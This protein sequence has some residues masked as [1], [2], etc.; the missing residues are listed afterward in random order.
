MIQKYPR[1]RF[2][3]DYSMLL[4]ETIRKKIL[5]IEEAI[6]FPASLLAQKNALRENLSMVPYSDLTGAVS[7]LVQKGKKVVIITG[8]YVPVGDPPATE[9]DGPPGA[10]ALARGLRDLGM[11][12]SLLSDE[13]TLSA[14]KAGLEILDLPEEE[15][16]IL[17]FPLD[18]SDRDHTSRMTN[19]EDQSSTSIRFAQDFFDS[20]PGQGLTHLIYIERVGPNH[21][22]ESFI[23]Q[24]RQGKPP[25]KEFE[26]ILPSSIRN[27]CFSSRLEDITRFTAKTHFLLELAAGLNLPVESIGIGDRGNE[28][29]A[30]KIPWE[31]FRQSSSTNR[32]AVFC[33]RVKT[34]TLI[35]CGISNWGGYALL[36]GAALAAGKPEILEKVTSEREGTV[37]DHLVRHGPAID[38]ITCK[39]DHS[40]DGIEFDDYVKVIERIKEIAFE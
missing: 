5:R 19:E 7:S 18:H 27:R 14:L 30:G 1:E 15:V 33:S 21:T 16:P 9:T 37:L 26:T 22:L 8:F 2:A 24:E 4:S 28:I 40:V 39:P 29:G 6:N 38:G 32:E 36:A 34:D 11:E 10:L 17:C 23:A 35:S 25:L 12:V 3:K 20:L 13:Y 31:V